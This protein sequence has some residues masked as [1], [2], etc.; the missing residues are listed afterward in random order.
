M[1]DQL[2]S[3]IAHHA[4][5]WIFRSPGLGNQSYSQ[6]CEDFTFWPCPGSQAPMCHDAA[7]IGFANVGHYILQHLVP[8]ALK[9]LH[10]VFLDGN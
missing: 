2:D 6:R 1:R 10:Q 7:G 9:L 5:I 8:A 3:A 4:D